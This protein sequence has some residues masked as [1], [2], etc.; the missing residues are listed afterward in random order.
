MIEDEAHP[1][2]ATMIKRACRI[3]D[4]VKDILERYPQ[5]KGDDLQLTWRYYMEYTE[6]RLSFQTFKALLLCP[7][8]ETLSRRRRELQHEYPALMPTERVRRKR[9]RNGQAHQHHYGKGLTL[10]DWQV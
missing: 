3:K 10:N 9:I 7:A 5:T 8:P 1:S 4:K 2:G 6:V